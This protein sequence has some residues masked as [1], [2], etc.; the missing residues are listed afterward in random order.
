[1]SIDATF[2][3]NETRFINHSC[4]PNLYAQQVTNENGE[5]IP[6]V[7]FYA[8]RQIEDKYSFLFNIDLV[9]N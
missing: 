1:M 9:K 8:L 7:N 5:I 4:S 2:Y 3:G 6:Q